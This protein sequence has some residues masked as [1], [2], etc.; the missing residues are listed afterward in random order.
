MTVI[1]SVASGAEVFAGGSVHI[2]GTLRGRAVAGFAGNAQARVFCSHFQAELLSINGVYKTA[3][4][5]DARL[6]NRPV[7][8]WLEESVIVMAALD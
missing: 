6:R 7:Q 1:G 3:D 5:V 2:Y 4:D 8:A